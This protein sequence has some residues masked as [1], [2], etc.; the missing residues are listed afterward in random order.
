MS[1]PFDA[2]ADPAQVRLNRLLADRMAR[3]FAWGVQ[4]CCIFAAD[5]VQALTGVDP[6]ADVRG[7]Y[8][9]AAGALATLEAQGGI[10]TVGARA[11]AP[12]PPLD[13]RAGDVGVVRLDAR[14]MLAVCV[15]ALWLAP[16]AGGLA[17]LPFTAAAQA[18]RVPRA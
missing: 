5:C 16:A 12:I 2:V 4:D 18:W 3:P 14:D 11:G 1:D 17:A 10:T 9:D 13:A 8:A 7:T 6:A 15:G